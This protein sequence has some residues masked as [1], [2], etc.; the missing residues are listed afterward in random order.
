M[1]VF[2]AGKTPALDHPGKPFP[3]AGSLD[4]DLLPIAKI[5]TRIS[6]PTLIGWSRDRLKILSDGQGLQ[7]L[8]LENA[9]PGFVDGLFFA[10]L[11]SELQTDPL[12]GRSGLI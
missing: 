4:F 12:A 5:S 1:R 11:E 7:P 2:P 9:G 3:L 10:R 8:L 6:S